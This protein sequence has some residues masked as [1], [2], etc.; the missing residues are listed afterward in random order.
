MEEKLFTQDFIDNLPDDDIEA[1]I[2]VSTEVLN[3]IESIKAGKFLY[4][5]YAFILTMLESRP[6][7]IKAGSPKFDVWEDAIKLGRV[8][9]DIRNIT[10]KVLK[11]RTSE[12]TFKR[13]LEFYKMQMK[14]G[15]SYEFLDSDYNR[16]QELI[17][18]IRTLTSESGQIEEK[19]KRRLLRKI[20]AL[21]QELHKRMSNLDAFWGLMGEAGV[22]LGKFGQDVKPLTDRVCEILQIVYR[23]QARA[24]ELPVGR[25]KPLLQTLNSMSEDSNTKKEK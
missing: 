2:V 14:P 8:L 22:A 18:E 21:Q 12:D 6:I 15:F 19:H 5:S 16:L 25:E 1:W 7:G 3:H 23:T 13:S 24:N 4:E 11:E 20:E 9:G 17:N 10:T